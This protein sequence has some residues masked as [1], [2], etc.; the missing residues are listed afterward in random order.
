MDVASLSREAGGAGAGEAGGPWRSRARGARGCGQQRLAAPAILA[1]L[2]VQAGVRK[3]ASVTQKSRDTLAG[4]SSLGQP[5]AGA[6]V[7]TGVWETSTRKLSSHDAWE[8]GQGGQQQQQQQQGL[9]L[10]SR[11]PGPDLLSLFRQ[12][13]S[14]PLWSGE[15]DS[16]GPTS[17]P[18]LLPSG[19]AAV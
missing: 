11:V 9:G 1:E 14:E 2:G 17:P 4:S 15:A 5:Q 19:P 10:H 6:S 7:G 3:L 12:R 8:T 18:P 13:P 16:S